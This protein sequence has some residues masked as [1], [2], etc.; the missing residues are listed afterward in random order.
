MNKPKH[1]SELSGEELTKIGR[2]AV[3]KAREKAFDRGLSVYWDRRGLRVREY[4]DG[5]IE[6]LEHSPSK[7]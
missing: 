1:I 5:Q 4:P 3:K 6:I 2:R 7:G